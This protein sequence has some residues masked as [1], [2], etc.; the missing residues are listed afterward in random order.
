MKLLVLLLVLVL[1]LL[2]LLLLL[3][4][5]RLLVLLVLALRRELLRRVVRV[6][7]LRRESRP[8]RISDKALEVNRRFAHVPLRRA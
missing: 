8:R 4:G 2:L 3:L 6:V 7:W 5:G 1:V